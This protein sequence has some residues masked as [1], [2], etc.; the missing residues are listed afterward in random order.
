M[1]E[2]QSS[3]WSAIRRVVDELEARRADGAGA[4]HLRSADHVALLTELWRVA[5][6]GIIEEVVAARDRGVEWKSIAAAH[7][8][9]IQT[10]HRKFRRYLPKHGSG[11]QVLFD[12][13]GG[14]TTEQAPAR[15]SKRGP[16]P[17][18]TV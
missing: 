16:R 12:V 6:R 4:A 11:E 9:T 18:G 1:R 14:E 15:R 5:G 2:V 8:V 13:D 3:T 10:A 7:G 17:I